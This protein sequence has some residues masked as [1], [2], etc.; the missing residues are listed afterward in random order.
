MALHSNTGNMKSVIP[1]RTVK[2]TH[3]VLAGVGVQAGADEGEN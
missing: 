2:V 1:P 3:D